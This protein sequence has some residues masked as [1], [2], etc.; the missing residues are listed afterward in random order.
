MNAGRS[1][2]T[3]PF[4]LGWLFLESIC[5]VV[6]LCSVQTRGKA[7]LYSVRP[8]SEIVICVFCRFC[9]TGVFTQAT[10]ENIG[11]MWSANE[12]TSDVI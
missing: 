9:Y 8:R 6:R 5:Q 2:K 7:T 1:V 12:L 3:G 4:S 10:N 11:H